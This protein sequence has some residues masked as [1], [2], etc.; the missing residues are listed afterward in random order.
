MYSRS[1]DNNYWKPWKSSV[2]Y[3]VLQKFHSKTIRMY[4]IVYS[5]IYLCAHAN[6]HTQMQ[7][8]LVGDWTQLTTR[9]SERDIEN[10]E[11]G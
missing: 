4:L 2:V 3:A 9:L 6:V 1:I 5:N 11:V 8:H 10:G 7:I